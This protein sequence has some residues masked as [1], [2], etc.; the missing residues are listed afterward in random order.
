MHCLWF[1]LA[2]RPSLPMHSR[3]F[4]VRHMMVT[5]VYSRKVWLSYL[6]PGFPGIIWTRPAC[7]TEAMIVLTVLLVCDS[8]CILPFRSILISVVYGHGVINVFSSSY[9]YSMNGTTVH[10]YYQQ[11]NRSSTNIQI[12][13]FSCISI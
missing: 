9:S 3:V 1:L 4:I 5:S 2:R 7:F 11:I 8:T 13:K 12:E 6:V 10:T